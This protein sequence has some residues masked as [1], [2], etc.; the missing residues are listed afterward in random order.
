M[1]NY[2]MD[3]SSEQMQEALQNSDIQYDG[4]ISAQD[5]LDELESRQFGGNEIRTLLKELINLYYGKETQEAD[6]L[7]SIVLSNRKS[8]NVQFF[9]DNI[10]IDSM[11]YDRESMYEDE[12]EPLE[13]PD[14]S[15]DDSFEEKIPDDIL[16]SDESTKVYSVPDDD[17]EPE[18]ETG[19]EK[20]FEIS[21]GPD[22]EEE[23]EELDNEEILDEETV[24]EPE[25]EIEEEAVSIQDI[26]DSLENA[27]RYYDALKYQYPIHN[28]EDDEINYFDAT[29]ENLIYEGTAISVSDDICLSISLKEDSVNEH[30]CMIVSD[31]E[32]VVVLGH[33]LQKED[34]SLKNYYIE[35]SAQNIDSEKISRTGIQFHVVFANADMNTFYKGNIELH[36]G[37]RRLSEKTLC[38]DFG[39]SNTTC[40][41]YTDDDTDN[42]EIVRFVDTTKKNHEISCLC[43]TMVYVNKIGSKDIETGK[44]Q[45]VE[46]LFG[47]DAQKVMIDENYNPKGSVFFEIKRWIASPEELE[48]ICDGTINAYVPRKEII[49]AYLHDIIRKAEVY[50]K[51]K[52]YKFHFSAPVKL[53]SKFIQFL[54]DDV[55]TGTVSGQPYQV[56][57]AQDS[58]DEGVAII[59]NYISEN[60]RQADKNN[61]EFSEE[62]KIMIIDCGGSTTDLASCHY[63]FSKKAVGYDL[64]L[65][66]HFENGN[67]NF[68]GNNITSRIFQLLKIKIAAYYSGK[69]TAVSTADLIQNSENEMLNAIDKCI[70]DGQPMHIYDLLDQKSRESEEILPTTFNG[71]SRYAK[72]ARTKQQTKRNF[73]YLWQLAEK[74]K[75]EFFTRTDIVAIDFDSESSHEILVDWKNLYFYIKNPEDTVPPLK[76]TVDIYGEDSVPAVRIN[77]KEIAALLRPDIY[78]L[79]TTIFRMDDIASLSQYDCIKLSG[80]SCKINLF[81]ELLKEF[82]PG[83]NLRTGQI[84]TSCENNP[85]KLKLDCVY[86]SI[87]YIRD[88]DYHRINSFNK[89]TSQKILY[90]V[91]AS[92]G[93]IDSHFLIEGTEKGDTAKPLYIEQYTANS[94]RLMIRVFLN[95][96]E[97]KLQNS[98]DVPIFFEKYEN[99]RVSLE[100]TPDADIFNSMEQMI[101]DRAY[102]LL[103]I[104]QIPVVEDG[105]SMNLIEDLLA[106]IENID[107]DDGEDRVLVFAVPNS[108]GYGFMLYQLLKSVENDTSSYYLTY[109]KSYTFEDGIASCSL[110]DGKNCI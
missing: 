31:D 49:S 5:I 28:L 82:V 32:E 50:L 52:F 46:Y 51:C 86:G 14:Y 54:Q 92:R 33:F 47:Y 109:Q 77:T 69:G 10:F 80:Q 104:T 6:A 110:F 1:D 103:S 22:E 95:T 81:Q 65:E 7:Q 21:E 15:I 98:F 91:E 102:P 79:L 17:A 48:E 100:N 66:T 16:K 45:N 67:S 27:R 13:E 73:Y 105:R 4:L 93:G 87:M 101:L 3:F 38:I 60:I 19:E 9:H 58:I 62:K 34:A 94:G 88:R 30:F 35:A 36:I 20:V 106:R 96:A 55:F 78:Y 74:I 39:T 2:K 71:T 18:E 72:T 70:K 85:E 108:D 37:K 43:P 107:L 68:G 57:S 64:Q 75:I 53:K 84:V 41:I 56:M 40:G 25:A 99:Q 44:A 11:N 24:E 23:Y 97:K 8:G 89:H 29:T 83:R 76:S 26:P 59:Y 90:N 12:E 61:Q 42:I 63:Q